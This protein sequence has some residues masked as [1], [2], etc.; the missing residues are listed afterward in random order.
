MTEY[1]EVDFD[2][3]EFNTER[4]SLL[5]ID[6]RKIW[7]PHSVMEVEPDA[8]DPQDPEPGTVG[9]ARWFAEKEGLV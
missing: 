4:A 8:A 6:D 1:I 7:V 2:N 9:I 5:V 3:C